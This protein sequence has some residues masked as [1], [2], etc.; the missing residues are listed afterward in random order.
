MLEEAH[1]WV[2]GVIGGGWDG[3]SHKG[4]M[5]PLEYSAF[6]PLFML[7]HTYVVLKFYLEA[8]ST[9]ASRNVDRLFAMYQA[10]HPDIYFTPDNIGNSGNV[11]LEDEQMV[12]ADTELL[13]FRKRDGGF[14]TTND[15]RNT[16]TLGYAYPETMRAGS[17]SDEEYQG[18]VTAAIAQ[19]YG[20]SAR[21]MLRA[22]H[23]T[24]GGPKLAGDGTF[25][26]WAIDAKA[27][28]HGLPPTFLVRF[29]LVGDFSS[30]SIVDVGSW[31]K[32]MPSSHGK[33]NSKRVS[34]VEKIYEGSVSLTSSLLD[35]VAAGKLESLEP[36]DVVPY[37]KDR[38][39]WKV[40]TV[41]RLLT[42]R[43]HFTA[44]DL[45]REMVSRSRT[46]ALMLLPS[47]S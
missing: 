18:S 37:L 4:H 45:Q 6:E 24:A 41:R 28:S 33:W 5:W 1:G 16:T 25:T 2:H 15:A 20:S 12:D 30:D 8:P 19:L 47:K 44:N 7:H 29:S 10:A 40:L 23:A 42:H 31:V 11:F 3:K 26:D 46:L 22:S 35:Q 38:L 43:Y 21:G 36:K 34:T 13:P 17:V 32:L 27:S 9:N 14:W 39:T